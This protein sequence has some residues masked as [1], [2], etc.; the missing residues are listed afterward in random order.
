[1]TIW[2]ASHKHLQEL[3][4]GSVSDWLDVWW[5]NSAYQDDFDGL[6]AQLVDNSNLEALVMAALTE[7]RIFPKRVKGRK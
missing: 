1:M 7:R 4:A 6:F 3:L 2:Q 5:T